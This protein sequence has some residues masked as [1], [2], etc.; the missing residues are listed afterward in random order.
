MY[1]SF[2]FAPNTAQAKPTPETTD[3]FDL[4]FRYR[5]TKLIA[6]LSVWYT[7]YSNRLASAYDPDLDRSVYRNLG[8]VNK[9]GIDGSV[10]YSVIPELQFYVFGS[11][12]KSKIKDDLLLTE[13]NNGTQIFSPTGG[14][15]ESGS[16]VFTLGGRA[17]GRLG[18][19]ELGVQA[20]RTGKRYINDSNLPVF[21]GAAGT[22]IYPAAAP[23]YTLVDL[24]ARLPLEFIG[25]N[26]KTY[27]Q[28]NVSN[29]FDKLYVG[30]FDGGNQSPTY[31]ANTGLITGYSNPI[32]VQIGA[33]RTF[34]GSFVIGF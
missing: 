5:S 23:A 3:N 7:K 20:K 1:N 11:Y 9:Y 13:L 10:S 34:M 24:D 21:T 29:L 25:L 16:P 15:R 12:L 27:L 2:Y 31:N 30:G 33:P 4:G 22:Q 14:K 26:K 6:Q 32:F 19:L 28:L 8:T 17:Q 18:P